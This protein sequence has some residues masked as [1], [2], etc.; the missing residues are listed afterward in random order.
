MV[1][2]ARR[3]AAVCVL[4]LGGLLP[5]VG[6]AHAQEAAASP[7]VPVTGVPCYDDGGPRVQVVY[8]YAE[9]QADDL[10]ERR[11]SLRD[12]A[13]QV[14]AVVEASARRTGGVRHVRFRT[15]ADCALDVKAVAV[16][17]VDVA[18]NLAAVKAAGALAAGDVAL[19]FVGPSLGTFSGDATRPDDDRPGAANTSNLGGQL[20]AVGYGFWGS[21]EGPTA[22]LVRALGAVATGAPHA[23]ASGGCSEGLDPLCYDDLAIPQALT[24]ECGPLG[25]YL[26]DCRNDDYFSTA[27]VAGSWLESHWNVADSVFLSAA[28]PPRREAVETVDVK[29]EG[30]PADGRVGPQTPLTVR[31]T[32]S[33]PLERVVLV[34]DRS[35]G[36]QPLTLS[37]STATGSLRSLSSTGSGELFAL[38]TDR[39]G[40]ERLSPV[41]TVTYVRGVRLRLGTTSEALRGTVPY[42]VT[43]DRS[44]D[45][46]GATRLL[47]L[48]PRT[49]TAAAVVLAD[50]PL[51]SGTSEY[52]GTVDTTL[53]PDGDGTSLL[54]VLADDKGTAVPGAQDVVRR[55]TSNQRPV[56]RLDVAEDAVLPTTSVLTASTSEPV[57]A[58]RF[59]QTTTDCASGRVLGT[60]T[61]APFSVQYD[62]AV[63]WKGPLH[64]WGLCATAVLAD[65][66]T[67]TVGPTEVTTTE[68]DAVELRLPAGKVLT[69]G[70][71]ALPVVVRAP[72]HRRLRALQLFET[73]TVF[74]KGRHLVLSQAVAEGASPTSVDLTIP[75]GVTG[76]TELY[77]RAVFADGTGEFVRSASVPVSVVPGPAPTVKLSSDT[78]TAGAKVLVSGTAPPGSQLRMWGVSRPASAFTLLRYGTV[79]ADGTYSAVLGPRSNTRVY[80][81]VLGGDR[82]AALPINVRSAVAMTVTRTGTRTYRFSGTVSPARAGRAVT[83]AR[84]LPTGAGALVRTTSGADGRWTATFRFPVSGTFDLLAVASADVVN[85]QGTSAVRRLAVR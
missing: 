30:V 25:R 18:A 45:Q 23:S 7:Y 80:V 68:P 59:V 51:V 60:A 24:E 54:L 65:G 5:A 44:G 49:E 43:L 47:L 50:R 39:L 62:A 3:T 61:T 73:S 77:V 78:I 42:T 13:A 85:A 37:G 84:R 12:A 57:S 56:L 22:V 71:N 66:T 40:R 76:S 33:A 36:V 20:G 8:L 35:P 69:V 83:V 21:V 38:A 53:L 16:P 26:L 11:A 31:V 55:S 46:L 81:E 79:P 14:D 2:R 74:V 75:P 63:D 28:A 6:T 32:D 17:K 58:V 1:S 9:G 41:T 64:R 70:S 27:P 67:T 52:T 19:A 4:V 48:R 15:G 72:S 82:T 34:S 29:V 10:S